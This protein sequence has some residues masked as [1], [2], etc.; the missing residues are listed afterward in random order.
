MTQ[1]F[2]SLAFLF[3]ALVSCSASNAQDVVAF[4]G[5]ENDYDFSATAPT[6]MDFAGDVDNTAS[7]NANLQVFLGDSANLDSNGGGGFVSYTSP[8]SGLTYG[9]T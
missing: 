9:T 4:W 1:L 5:W 3:I 7:A 6:K 2:R 8:V